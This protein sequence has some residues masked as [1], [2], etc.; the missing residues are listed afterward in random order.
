MAALV[1]FDLSSAFFTRISLNKAPYKKA[2]VIF[3]D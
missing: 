1:F 3:W 2:L